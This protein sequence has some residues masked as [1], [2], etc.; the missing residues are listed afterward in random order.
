MPGKLPGTNF[1]VPD[2][3]FLPSNSFKIDIP[4][5]CR[6]DEQLSNKSIH[7]DQ[8][9]N[10]D[11]FEAMFPQPKMNKE[12]DETSKSFKSAKKN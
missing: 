1:K 5:L 11:S 10:F 4:K 12:Y 8:N 7:L 2:V 9:R 6:Q 3:E